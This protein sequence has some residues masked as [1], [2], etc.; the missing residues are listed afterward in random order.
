[1]D[2]I[3]NFVGKFDNAEDAREH[4]KLVWDEYRMQ[5]TI[6]FVED[7]VE[8]E[9]LDPDEFEFASQHMAVLL[10]SSQIAVESWNELGNDHLA[11]AAAKRVVDLVGGIRRLH[12]IMI[13]DFSGPAAGNLT[14]TL[15]TL[16]KMR[17]YISFV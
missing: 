17:R 15:E 16:Y 1:M 11:R 8:G 4:I 6:D 2:H 14:E 5:R 7:A 13:D 9:T 10:R 12:Q 3:V